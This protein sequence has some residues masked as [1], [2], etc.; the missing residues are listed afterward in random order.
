MYV[1][2]VYLNRY[3]HFNFATNEEF[4]PIKSRTF[5]LSN[6]ESY[7]VVIANEALKFFERVKKETHPE[8]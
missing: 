5:D 8:I 3:L 4:F 6:Y 1:D 7:P 2:K